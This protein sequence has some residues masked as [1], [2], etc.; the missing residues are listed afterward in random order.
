[1]MWYHASIDRC[2][3]RVLSPRGPEFLMHPRIPVVVLLTSA[4]TIA[5]CTI[6][7][8][9][10]AQPTPS[11]KESAPVSEKAPPPESETKPELRR[12]APTT[13]R[14]TMTT[15][16]KPPSKRPVSQTSPEDTVMKGPQPP[17]RR[18]LGGAPV[19]TVAREPE[20]PARRPP[21]VAPPSRDT[22]VSPPPPPIRRPIDAPPPRDTIIRRLPTERE[23]RQPVKPVP[24]A[25]PPAVPTPT[26]PEAEATPPSESGAPVTLRIPPGQLPPLGQCRVWIESRP[27]GRQAR[28]RSCLDIEKSAPA[29]AL[30]LERPVNQPEVIRVRYI[31]ERQPGVV[32]VVRIFESATGAWLR[33]ESGREPSDGVELRKK[34]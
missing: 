29:G 4:I 1:M 23:P 7:V 6:N 12:P 15:E 5:G 3:A 11:T 33:D 8:A 27:P 16:S 32:R 14:D 19:D 24:Q 26:S 17:V 30:I 22:L 18:P 9:P 25:P 2:S 21:A 20:P 31:D 10:A 34:T 28:P 13:P